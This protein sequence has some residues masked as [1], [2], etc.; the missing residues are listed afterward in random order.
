MQGPANRA[1]SQPESMCESYKKLPILGLHPR[2]V[3][4]LRPEIGLPEKRLP[5]EGGSMYQVNA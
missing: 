4:E 5:V 2:R 1:G 3:D